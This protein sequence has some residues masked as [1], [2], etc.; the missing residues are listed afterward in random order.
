MK[1]FASVA[2]AALAASVA[3]MSLAQR[4]H[5]PQYEVPVYNAFAPGEDLVY[6]VKYGFIKGGEG[7]F[8]VVDTVID[9]LRVNHI[10]VAGRTTGVADLFYEVRDSYE[11]FLDAETQLPV[12]SKRNISEG[13]YRYNDVVSY[14]RQ[15]NQLSKSVKRRNKPLEVK[16]QDAP[17]DIV[18][19]IGAFYHARNNAFDS[20]LAVGD[21]VYYKTFFSNEVYDLNIRYDGLETLN[22]I[23]GPTACYKF[24]PVTEVGRSFKNKDDMHLWVTADSR[25]VPVRI[26]FDMKVGSFTVDL[27]SA[28]G[29]KQGRP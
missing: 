20:R 15:N 8:T 23:F 16:T 4:T 26:K 10:T 9:G 21:T 27:A 14:D 13:R 28:K 2:A 1:I 6:T 7:R 11:S 3:C 12:L 22:T 25:R 18:D 17:R 5:R 19:I 24:T 29:L